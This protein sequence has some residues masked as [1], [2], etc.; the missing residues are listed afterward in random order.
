LPWILLLVGYGVLPLL[1]D[2]GRRY[3]LITWIVLLISGPV[4]AAVALRRPK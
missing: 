4:Y 3:L 2:T 1:S